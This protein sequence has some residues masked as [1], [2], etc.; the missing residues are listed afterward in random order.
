MNEQAKEKDKERDKRIHAALA[1]CPREFPPARDL[2]PGIEHALHR[3]QRKRLQPRYAL[4]ASFVLLAGLMV[5]VL[6][7]PPQTQAPMR[8]MLSELRAEHA[9]NKQSLLVNYENRDPF[10]ED[11]QEQMQQL[12]ETEAI[13]YQALRENPSNLQLLPLLRQV[14]RKQLELIDA[15]HAPPLTSI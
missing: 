13:I 3:Q 5:W 11:W 8:D 1:A 12:E 14:Q 9:S 6:Q 7:W 10:F 2:W 15:V 4:A